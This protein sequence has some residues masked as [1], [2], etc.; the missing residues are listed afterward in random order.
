MTIAHV[1]EALMPLVYMAAMLALMVLINWL[2]D[3]L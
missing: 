2:I 3:R 1:V